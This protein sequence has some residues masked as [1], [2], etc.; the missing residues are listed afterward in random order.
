[1]QASQILTSSFLDILFENRNKAYG[2]Y[3]LRKSYNNRLG[4]SLLI[5]LSFLAIMATLFLLQNEPN[6]TSF[7]I[8]E[9]PPNV[10]TV[11]SPPDKI[12]IPIVKKIAVP[13]AVK[14]VHN[15]TPIIV[16]D[17]TNPLPPPDIREIENAQS[18]FIVS[19]GKPT[20]DI[21]GPP[22]N[23]P[24]S[25][26]LAAPAIHHESEDS[27]RITVE[28][29][30]SFPG[31]ISEWSKYLKRTIEQSQDQFTNSDY[32][33]CLVK[34][35]VNKYGEVSDV[36]AVTMQHTRLAAVAVKVIKGGP[37]WIPAMQN[38][39]KVSAYRTQPITLLS[40]DE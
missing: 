11:I 23:I 18:G 29:E 10:T 39:H 35:I 38:G 25:N 22:E 30:A 6:D 21:I 27:V 36:H 32:G 13:V 33:T 17:N 40:E 8:P 19:E 26:I 14:T 9:S 4:V 16:K 31:G 7:V 37:R 24:G 20:I 34:F 15:A 12:S 3:D 2:A 28:I 5:L 1:M